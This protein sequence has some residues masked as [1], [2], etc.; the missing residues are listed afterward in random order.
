MGRAISLDQRTI[1]AVTLFLVKMENEASEEE[2]TKNESSKKNKIFDS[3]ATDSPGV[4]SKIWNFFKG[5][6]SKF[7]SSI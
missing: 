3:E 4:I 7:I 2:K 6:V 5:A 1:Y